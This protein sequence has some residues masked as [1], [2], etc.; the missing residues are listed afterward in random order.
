MLSNPGTERMAAEDGPRLSG[1]S[2]RAIEGLFLHGIGVSEGCMRLKRPIG[3]P[4]CGPRASAGCRATKGPNI[5]QPRRAGLLALTKI[6]T[7]TVATS[8]MAAPQIMATVKPWTV[9]VT[10]LAPT[11][12]AR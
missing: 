9:A 6:A 4:S 5:G 2:N 10:M 7:G 3:V 1:R 12:A 11:W 8:V